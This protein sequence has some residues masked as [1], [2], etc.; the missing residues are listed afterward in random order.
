MP[1]FLTIIIV[2]FI[3]FRVKMKQ[4]APSTSEA[5]RNYWEREH[6]ANY[7]RKRDI[8]TLDYIEIPEQALPFLSP[9]N[10]LENME[11]LAL[12]Q[13]VKERMQ[14]KMINLYNFSNIELK[15]KF[16]SANL[17]ELANC[18]QN[19]TTFL[20]SLAKWGEFVYNKGDFVRARQIMEY[21]IS[22]DSDI[23]TVYTTLGKIY[24]QTNSL[25]KL[26]ELIDLVA[27]SDFARKDSILK[28]LHLCKLEY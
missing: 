27:T 5:D 12:E 26:D 19:F 6:Q 2:F 23:S 22:I 21:A 9:K 16:G 20:R 24:V 8:S 10:D 13:D 18:E 17:E 28:S 1:I 4:N 14:H 15:E 25:D 3:W 7:V 11:E